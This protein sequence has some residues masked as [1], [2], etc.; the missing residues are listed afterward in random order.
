M[1]TK[2]GFIY[3][4]VVAALCMG[5]ASLLAHHSWTAQ[6]DPTKPLE[7]KGMVSKF[8]WTNPHARFYVDARSTGGDVTTWN[9]ELASPNILLRNGWTRNT[10]KVGDQVSVT[11]FI[12]RSNPKMAIAGEVVDG[13]GKKLF[14]SSTN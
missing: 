2:T 13:T 10:L 8:E 6:Y 14:A 3:V 11:G 4:L 1:R 9:F 7:V 12:A 5:G